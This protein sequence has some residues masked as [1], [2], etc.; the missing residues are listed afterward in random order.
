MKLY[1]VVPYLLLV[2]FM[3]GSADEFS[4]EKAS[5]IGRSPYD[6][7]AVAY[8]EAYENGTVDHARREALFKEMTL[9]S[10]KHVWPW[11]FLNRIIG[12]VEG[13]GLGGTTPDKKYFLGVRGMDLYGES[14]DLGEF[15][16]N[17]RG[18]FRAAR[19]SGSPGVVV[20]L[21]S[22]NNYKN[23][24]LDYLAARMARDPD[25]V[26]ERL[27]ML[28]ADLAD[29]AAH[30]YPDAIVWSFFGGVGKRGKCLEASDIGCSSVSLVVLGF[31]D[32]CNEREYRL[33][34]VAGGEWGLGY[35]F[36]SVEALRARIARRDTDYGD[37]LL[38]YGNLR[39]AG[40]IA[41]WPDSCRK[42]N[43]LLME[44]CAECDVEDAAGFVP[45]FRELA[46]SYDYVWI[47]AAS[48]AGYNPFDDGVATL[49]NDALEEGFR[50]RVRTSR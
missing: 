7:V 10:G 3:A 2:S 15:L 29:I 6:G 50:D 38:K 44:R 18:A 28:G 27:V 12:H 17:W 21:E 16:K 42:T 46:R 36:S 39:L 35:C 34:F 24:G 1:S 11:V 43:W 22:Y 47:Y 25:E 9:A 14:G 40:T 48:M 5:A 37:T 19:S 8:Q 45:Y 33:T 49:M 31:L 26:R 41:P 30:E 13:E 20:D 32:R 4:L 23:Y